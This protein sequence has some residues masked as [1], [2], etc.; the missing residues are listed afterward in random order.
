MLN[1]IDFLKLKKKKKKNA[2]EFLH[3]L[4]LHLD[5]IYSIIRSEICKI[6][7]HLNNM[8]CIK[9]KYQVM[10]IIQLFFSN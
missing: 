9:V 2:L 1:K 6:L 4:H 5:P 8:N 7:L 10:Q 3:H